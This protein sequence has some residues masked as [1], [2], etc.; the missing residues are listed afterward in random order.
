MINAPAKRGQITAVL[1]LPSLPFQSP[2]QISF[3]QGRWRPL[4]A[5]RVG[6]GARRRPDDRD[7]SGHGYQTPDLE[8]LWSSWTVLARVDNRWH[9]DNEEHGQPIAAC[10]LKH[11]LA[12][13]W[14]RLIATD[15]L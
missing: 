8:I 11:P 5:R 12:S 7:R 13:D 15:Q 3:A 14:T 4:L 2:K 1:N 10:T 6:T 9:L